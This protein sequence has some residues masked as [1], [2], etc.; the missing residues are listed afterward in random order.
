MT[1]HTEHAVRERGFATSGTTGTPLTWWRT[2]E[3]LDREASMVAGRILGEFDRIVSFAPARHLYGCLYGEVLPRLRGV[4]VTQWADHQDTMPELYAGERVLLVCLPATWQLLG[5]SLTVLARPAGV[6]ALHGTGP[7]TGAVRATVAA[8]PRL[9]AVEIFGSTETG[10][11]AHRPIAPDASGAADWRLFPDVRPLAADGTP[12]HGT[13]SGERELIVAGP[14]IGRPDGADAP[15]DLWHTGD[16]VRFTGPATFRH[17]GRH[18]RLVKVNGIRCDLGRV[19]R[20]LRAAHPG[21]SI[22]CVPVRDPV[23][24]EHYEVLCG[25]VDPARIRAD[26][27]DLLPGWPSPRAVRPAVPETGRTG[28]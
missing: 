3:L 2:T 26:I 5:H 6:V 24:G 27:A 13:G 17:L 23:R 19:E 21:S 10:A 28:R 1:G 25:G 20:L 22:R 7:L 4:P 8:A 9:R 12:L 15:P 14:R 11:L 18:S 16:L